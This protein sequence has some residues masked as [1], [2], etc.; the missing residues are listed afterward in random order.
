[1][2]INKQ[3]YTHKEKSVN[4]QDAA[5][6]YKNVKIVCDGCS[7]GKHTE[8]G[9]KMFCFKFIEHLKE[10]DENS[11]LDIPNMINDVFE[12]V[13]NFF[14][15]DPQT[16]LDYMTFTIFVVYT[17]NDGMNHVYYCGDGYILE[18]LEDTIVFHRI[19]NG[20][21]PA[22]YAYNYIPAQYLKMYKEGIGLSELH[23]PHKIGIATDGLRFVD[24]CVDKREELIKS[25]KNGKQI[26]VRLFFNKY[27]SELFDDV[28][29]VW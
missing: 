21:Y 23:T 4:C 3:G 1:M 24:S 2:V 6:E 9:A 11:A 29:L 7:E 16:L 12:D 19:D 22:Y 17:D 28:S 18:E 20:K 13:L 8:V 27:A 26:R 15:D 14:G 25:L 5:T 10:Y